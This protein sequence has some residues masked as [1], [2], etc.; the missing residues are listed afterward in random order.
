M[1]E[2]WLFGG[3]A[4]MESCHNSDIYKPLFSISKIA[5]TSKTSWCIIILAE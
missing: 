2:W 3:G 4:E 5:L 1:G